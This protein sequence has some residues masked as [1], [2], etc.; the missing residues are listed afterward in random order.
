[1]NSSLSGKQGLPENTKINFVD[2][3]YFCK[4]LRNLFFSSLCII[5]LCICV[6]K[7]RKKMH[8]EVC[9]NPIPHCGDISIELTNERGGHQLLVYICLGNILPRVVIIQASFMSKC[10][11]GKM[12]YRQ[13][14]IQANCYLGELLIGELLLGK[15]L[16]NHS[17]YPSASLD[18]SQM[19]PKLKTRRWPTGSRR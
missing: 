3:T 12:L 4:I 11:L 5:F 6:Y 10:Y 7:L 1:M 17:D 18:R 2:E 13:I 15:L 14:V 8:C 16:L 9:E 19:Y